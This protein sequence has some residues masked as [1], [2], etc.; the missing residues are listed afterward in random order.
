[1][2]DEICSID[3]NVLV[4]AYDVSEGKKH[5]ICKHLID[6]SWR[7]QEKYSISTQN[8]SEF[9]VVDYDARTVLSVIVA[10]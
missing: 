3:T 6:K 2:N 1:M 4:Y 10:M 7:L 5:E 9:C 8:L